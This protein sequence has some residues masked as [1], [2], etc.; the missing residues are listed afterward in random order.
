[1]GRSRFV[2]QIILA[3][4]LAGTA[5]LLSFR[6]T[7]PAK[8]PTQQTGPAT[9]A[10]VVASAELPRGAK[11]TAEAVKTVP[12]LKESLPA[13]YFKTPQELEGRVLLAPVAANEPITEN[14]LAPLEVASGG[15]SLQIPPGKRAVAVQGNKVLGMSGF[16]R[17]GNRVDVMVTMEDERLPDEIV[18]KTVLE[19][20]RVLATGTEMEESADGRVSPVDTYTLELS[21]EEAEALSL[22]ATKGTLHF[23][24]RNPTDNGSVLTPGA[25]IVRTMEKLKSNPPRNVPKVVR[26]AQA[27]P[28]T[29][30]K[31]V[32]V[33]LGSDV[34]KI[35]F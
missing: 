3:M 7:A 4:L 9:F 10:V 26:V 16:I 30:T 22:A 29:Q 20:L 11:L 28:R 8:A 6:L 14:R 12:Y 21:P 17:P 19:N 15:I 13:Q 31:T 5:G 35:E 25:D 33:I 2:M 27:Q 1:M 23:A 32:E 24:L 34:S 18:T